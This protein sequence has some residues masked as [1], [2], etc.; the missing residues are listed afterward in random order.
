MTKKPE[1]WNL[2]LFFVFQNSEES[3]ENERCKHDSEGYSS[4]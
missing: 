1:M 2:I 4:Y 3:C